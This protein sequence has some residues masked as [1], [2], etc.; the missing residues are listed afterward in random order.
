[1]SALKLTIPAAVLLTG[2]FV[3]T[4]NSYGTAEFA[5]KEKKGCTT[6][7]GKMVSDKSK[8]AK[9]LNETGTCY[10]DNHDLSKCA[11]PKK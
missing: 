5:K 10:K 4:T 11:A 1:M 7:H 2:F 3:C 8:M 9:N 6:C